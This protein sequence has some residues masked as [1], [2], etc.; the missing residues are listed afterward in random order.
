VPTT[1]S[2]VEEFQSLM[3]SLLNKVGAS[4]TTIRLDVPKHGFAVNAVVAEARAPGINS[5]A[6]EKSLEQRKTQTAS[7]LERERRILVQN[8]CLN[9]EFQPPKELMQIYGTRA[10]M[11]APIERD[12]ALT[13]WISVHYNPS[14]REWTPAEVAAL[15]AAVRS[16]HAILD[17]A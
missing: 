5:I 14:P 3:S 13:G 1:E 12:G 16:A 4:R 15:E 8:D 6:V 7:W 17:Q 11:L 2:L 9:A 10:Q